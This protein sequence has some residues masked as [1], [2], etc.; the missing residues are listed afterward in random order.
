M[1]ATL[2]KLDTA[3]DIAY[4]LGVSPHA[5]R[6]WAR[7]G[8]IRKF[9]GDRY[10]ALDAADYLDTRSDTNNRRACRTERDCLP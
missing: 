1:T 3:A 10:C 5:I 2:T 6:M 9:P 4:W 7:R 8:Y